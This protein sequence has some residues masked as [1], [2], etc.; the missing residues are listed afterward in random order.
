MFLNPEQ[1]NVHSEA[2]A[3]VEMPAVVPLRRRR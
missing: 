2:P 3:N 1:F